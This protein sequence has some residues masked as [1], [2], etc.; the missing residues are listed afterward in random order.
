MIV[1]IAPNRRDG[2]SSFR[3]LAKYMTDGITQSGEAPHKYSWD[4]LTQYITQ[5]S[6]LNAMGDDVEKTIAVEVGNVSCLANA[7]AEMYA[8]AKM[9]PRVANPVYHYILSWPE[10]ERPKTEEIFA[11]ARHT[12]AALGMSEH[13]YIVAIHA[14]TDNLHA[15]IEVNRVHPRTFKAADNFRDYLV[16]HRAAREIELKFGWQHDN[17]MFQVVEVNGEKRVVRNDD[18]VDPDFAPTRPGARKAEVWSGEASLET[19]CKGEPAADLKEAL[20]DP[21]TTSWQ[22]I[23]RVLGTHGLEL[24]EAG[25]GGWKVVDVSEATAEKQGKN[26]AVSA[27]AAFR[28]MKRA[29]LEKRFGAFQ[30]R[31]ED[32]PIDAPKRTYKR[33]PLKRLE[34]RLARKEARDALYA[35]FKDEQRRAKQIQA[36]AKA[37]LTPLVADD[38]KRHE[39]VRIAYAQR[40]NQIKADRSLTPV[41][42]QQAYV[43][44]KMTMLRARTQLIDQIR[45]ERA[46]RR[47]LLPPLPSWR[48]WVETEALRGDEAAISALRGMV[49]QDG[50]NSKKKEARSVATANENAI[51]PALDQGTDPS[52]RFGGNLVWK[53]SKNGSVNYRFSDGKPAFRDEGERLTFGRKDVTDDALSASLRYSA[54]RWRDGIRIA[55]GDFA[56]KERVVRMAVANGIEV[57]NIELRDLVGQ[58]RAEMASRQAVRSA[59]ADTLPVL[60]Q[61]SISPSEPIDVLIRR[62]DPK[63][64]VTHQSP[65]RKT[66]TGPVVAQNN[67]FIA[68]EVGRNQVVVH[69]RSAFDRTPDH[70]ERVTI[71]YRAGKATLQK[72]RSKT[73]REGR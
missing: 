16:L 2:R 55:G 23:H 37:E 58:V 62:A 48:A 34:S 36:L 46:V 69:R 51:L 64:N 21:R 41:Q 68:Q 66:Y 20:K 45:S 1:K 40:R 15:H 65:D 71:H 38:K 24:R 50:R 73:T 26:L 29:E 67:E 8:T 7:P 28:F 47:E 57:K 13:Q 18:Y 32:L 59:R 12:L 5:E 14:N 52:V 63:A 9:A 11:A 70:G 19:W 42:K 72:P 25:G 56:F 49:Y 6:V 60:P 17:G 35:R 33:D 10:H 44:A 31:Q 53:V 4:D 39:A 54:D 3:D 27:S 30:S 22:D 61:A 43:L